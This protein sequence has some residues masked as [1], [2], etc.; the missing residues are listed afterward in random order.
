MSDS[1]IELSSGREWACEDDKDW[2]YSIQVE[3]G[4]LVINSAGKLHLKPGAHLDALI[5][6]LSKVSKDI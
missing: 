2:S 1:I 6:L 5:Q 3:D 4:F